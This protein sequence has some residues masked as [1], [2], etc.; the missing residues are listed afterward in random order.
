MYRGWYAEGFDARFD[1]AMKHRYDGARITNGHQLHKLMT[2]D[3]STTVS[4]K[5]ARDAYDRPHDMTIRTLNKVCA[6]LGVKSHEIFADVSKE[7]N[8]KLK[9][10]EDAYRCVRTRLD[11]VVGHFLTLDPSQQEQVAQMV[12]GIVPRGC[13][14]EPHL[15]ACTIMSGQMN[16]RMEGAGPFTDD[17]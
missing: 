11:D 1:A 13:A 16:A 7:E 14:P 8:E 10:I 6:A 3:A 2:T 17:V 4:P 15:V 12:S 5:T 9:A